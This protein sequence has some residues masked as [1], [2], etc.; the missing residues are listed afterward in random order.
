MPDT[1][2]SVEIARA[3]LDAENPA[4]A[5]NTAAAN[6]NFGDA[7]QTMAFLNPQM[8]RVEMAIQQV[9]YP[10]A[11]WAEFI[12]A[13][14]QGTVWTPGS[15]FF[16]GDV[17]GKPEWF[18][19]AAD[20]MPY[21]DA[22]QTQFMQENHI[23]GIGFKY[24]QQTLERGRMLGID[25][26]TQKADAAVKVAERDIH[27]I[28]MQG[29]GLKFATGFVNDP[30]ATQNASGNTFAHMTPDEMVDAV[31]AELI[32][33]ETDTKETYMADTVVF[34]Q[35]LKAALARRMTDTGTSVLEYIRGNAIV[36]NL[37]IKF[38][39]HL[40]AAGAGATKRMVTLQ[41]TN[42]VHRFHIPGG[43]YQFGELRRVGDYSWSRPGIYAIGGYEVR[44]PKAKRFLDAI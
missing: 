13:D 9:Q 24:D 28:A 38:S 27:N 41:N 31:N 6:V 37:T 30:L 25:V 32:G 34:P 42:D 26:V 23:R 14:T 36:E 18:D 43:G 39:R 3:V 21:A 11:N 16:S 4:L 33:V 17:A 15:I 44:I 10:N 40:N 2:N 29:D 5:F 22:S 1:Y 12:P 35:T 8:M 7:Q 19:V 20:D